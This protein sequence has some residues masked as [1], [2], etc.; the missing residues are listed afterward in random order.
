LKGDVIGRG[1]VIRLLLLSFFL[2][3]A[4]QSFG[5]DEQSR[6]IEGAKKEGKVVYW[7]TG[8]TPQLAKAF[9]EGFKKRYGLS[10]I[11]VVFSPT[12]TTEV[13]A[14]VSQELKMK[15]LSVDILSG[16]MPEFYYDLLRAG[17]VMKY[18]SPEYKYY[19][20]IKGL[21]AEPGYW[22][23]TNAV[24]SV[25]MWNPKHT[26]RDLVAYSD[27]LDPAFKGL[28]VSGDP[29]KSEA[30]LMAYMGWRKIL[31]REFFMKLAK[32]DIFF[33]M[34]YPDV[35]SRVVTGERPV[36]FLGNS[37]TAYVAATEGGDIKVCYPR[38]GVVMLTNPFLI[39]AK[40]PHPNA[41]RLFIDYVSGDEGQR[42]MAEL[43]GYFITRKGVKISPKL[44]EFT[45]PITE[46]NVIPMDWKSLTEQETEKARKEFLEVFG[47]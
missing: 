20:M 32:Q 2:I 24:A 29:V 1:K 37:R 8:L 17:E 46:I 13:I 31:N 27:L 11:E 18:D 42:L 38:E 36:T 6:L 10:N 45:P 26:K 19:P 23:G 34:R 4:G 43:G 41:A 5:A 7:A 39:L 28:M 44:R 12:R 40:A 25:L 9:E 47:K 33:L 3:R 30:A 14:K 16:T 21:D 15:R 22:A 35:T